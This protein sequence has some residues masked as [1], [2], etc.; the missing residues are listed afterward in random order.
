MVASLA[1]VLFS[2]DIAK[3]LLSATL[4]LAKPQDSL[5]S[6]IC[7]FEILEKTLLP[8]GFRSKSQENNTAA[9]LA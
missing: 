4:F 6:D 5:R 3:T 2:W 1:A 8:I 7:G 9:R